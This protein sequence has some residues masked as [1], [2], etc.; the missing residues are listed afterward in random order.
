MKANLIQLSF[1]SFAHEIIIH[2]LV[3][4]SHRCLFLNPSFTLV[5][6]TWSTKSLNKIGGAVECKYSIESDAH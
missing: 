4:F 5:S 6:G 2:N 1:D 3:I